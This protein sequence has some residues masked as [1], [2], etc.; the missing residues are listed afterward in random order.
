MLLAQYTKPDMP[1]AEAKIVY[2]PEFK[3]GDLVFP[4][5]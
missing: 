4:R 2:P 5:R 1:F 3:T